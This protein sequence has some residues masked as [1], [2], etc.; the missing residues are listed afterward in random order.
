MGRLDLS[1]PDS[2]LAHARTVSKQDDTA[3]T[4]AP[5]ILALQSCAVVDEYADSR[6][7]HADVRRWIA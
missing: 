3:I 7:R 5:C 4:Q 2:H 1:V 6:R